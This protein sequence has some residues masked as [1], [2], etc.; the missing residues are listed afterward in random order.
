MQFA[1]AT[2]VLAAHLMCMNVAAGAPLIGIWLDW[3]TRRGDELSVKLARYF[4]ASAL[5][6]LVLGAALGV[7]LGWL[8]W[9]PNYAALWQGPLSYKLKWGLFELG[10][11]VLLAGAV[12]AWRSRATQ[13][14]GWLGRSFLALLSSTN[15]LYHFP[16]LFV[17]AG[18]L[19]DEGRY[20][21]AVL[22]GARFRELM[23][24]RETPALAVHFT[25]A[26]LAVAGMLLIGYALR[27]AR[28]GKPTESGRVALWGGMWALVPT[29]AQ[30]PVGLWVLF[31][32]PMH[33]Q[34]RLMGADGATTVL[35]VISLLAAFWLLR[36]LATIALGEMQ[37]GSLVR[38]MIAMTAVLMLMTATHQA[39]R[40]QDRLQ[41]EA[42]PQAVSPERN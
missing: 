30:L 20:D 35:F 18:R 1:V 24:A 2:I 34:S 12:W 40:R 41:S 14:R 32:L 27:L 37:R 17:V 23:F 16:A 9:T 21:G 19:A 42:Q 15:L 3:R 8:L 38:S 5:V 33:L 29:V 39:A 10:F 22:A 13:G 11:S 25:L 26:S 28:Q 31:A 36:E 6:G 7:L 4:A